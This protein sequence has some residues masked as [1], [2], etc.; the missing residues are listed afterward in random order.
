MP[1]L[2]LTGAGAPAERVA[3]AT[4]AGAEVVVAGDGS[5][6]DPARAVRELAARGCA[7]S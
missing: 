3:E 2:V 1:T 5:A 7:A 6:V 4:R